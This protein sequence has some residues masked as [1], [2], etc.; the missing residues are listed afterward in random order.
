MGFV[1][2]DRKNEQRDARRL[3]TLLDRMRQRGFISAYY[4]VENPRR[5]LVT[6]QP[7]GALLEKDLRQLFRELGPLAPADYKLLAEVFAESNRQPAR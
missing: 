5:I 4:Y 6:W 7:R 2:H 3:R 1:K